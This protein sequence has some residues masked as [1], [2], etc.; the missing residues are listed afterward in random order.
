[1]CNTH[2]VYRGHLE[3]TLTGALCGVHKQ[4]NSST[5]ALLKTDISSFETGKY[6][7]RGHPLPKALIYTGL[8]CVASSMGRDG[9]CVA[10]RNGSMG[11]NGIRHEQAIAYSLMSSVCTYF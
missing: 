7:I 8:V 11:R 2:T 4:A 5:A 9:K 1:M 10:T 6:L 3:F